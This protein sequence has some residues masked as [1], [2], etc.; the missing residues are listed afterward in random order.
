MNKT[1]GTGGST[2]STIPSERRGSAGIL[3]LPEVE[4]YTILE[5][6]GSGAMGDVFAAYDA[7]LDRKVAL[8]ILPENRRGSGQRDQLLSEARTLA[9]LAHPNVVPVYDVGQARG[10][11]F[12]AMEFVRGENV[13]EWLRQS[14]TP[15]SVAA[16]FRD[17][18]LGLAAAHGAGLV[19]R[20]V[21]PQNL[22]MGDDGRVR[23]ADFGL[24]IW[25]VHDTSEPTD[26][27]EFAGSPAYMAPEQLRREPVDA[28]TDQFG[29][30]V[31][32][33][34]AL[35]GHRPFADAGPAEMLAAMEGS[36][37]VISG[38]DR[39]PTWL[40]TAVIRGLALKP[41]DR[42]SSCRELAA[43]LQP[44]QPRVTRGLIAAGIVAAT[45]VSVALY[46]G[47]RSGPP[48]VKII[49]PTCDAVTAP[50]D[51]IWNAST[52]ATLA[53]ALDAAEPGAS[54]RLIER[55]A[56]YAQDWKSTQISSCQS[57]RINHSWPAELE[58]AAQ[59][60]L[61]ARLLGFSRTINALTIDAAAAKNSR[62]AVS[63][64]RPV[65]PCGDPDYLRSAA[66]MA[67]DPSKRAQLTALEDKL[68]SLQIDRLVGRNEMVAKALPALRDEAIKLDHAAAIAMVHLL[69]GDLDRDLGNM[70][71]AIV[72]HTAGYVAARAGRAPQ[73]AAASATAL[74]WE[75]GLMGEEVDRASDWAAI[76]HAEA[77]TLKD[78]SVQMAQA[79]AAGALADRRGDLPQATLLFGQAVDL[80]LA[81]YGPEHYITATMQGA[82]A[83]VLGAA[84]KFDQAVAPH[85]AAIAV[86]E[87]WEG[88]DGR[89]V[90]RA[91]G[92]LALTESSAGLHADAQAH[93]QRAPL[94]SVRLV[95]SII[96]P[97]DI[98]G[99]ERS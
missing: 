47:T 85:R 56:S 2:E 38:N 37:L 73:S 27:G 76:A 97:D 8:K 78:G 79:Y 46:L 67:T 22:L 98:L 7:V 87:R 31:S 16:V 55:L 63:G 69:Q 34:E 43:A 84:G 77:S 49:A 86:L 58:P 25:S 29:L 21:K 81:N 9:K 96:G 60:C 59:R 24:A 14:R 39:V 1:V 41:S 32:L 42:F 35:Y 51:R 44:P 80:A 94:P 71:A 11:I 53:S 64:L 17:A 54:S 82:L 66:E 12:F 99:F 6:I 75:Y 72:E 95:R 5:K 45:A 36:A 74:V 28:R 4:R 91:L 18:A 90:S 61:D 23:V 20:D 50:L 3:V 48:P 92:N 68:E 65:R 83:S 88:P 30:C 62:G 13:V 19:H 93:A 52:K 26:G 15:E 40:H 70:K 33:F 89:G 57:V 10:S